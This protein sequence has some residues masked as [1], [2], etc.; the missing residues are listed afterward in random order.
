MSWQRV[1]GPGLFVLVGGWPG[2]GKSTLARALAAELRLPLLA[3]DEI[4]EAVARCVVPVEVARAR[5]DA[6]ADARHAAHFDRARTNDELWAPSPPLG[7]GSMIE[8]DTTAPTD[9]ALVASR[10][11]RAVGLTASS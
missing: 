11:L 10:V 2:S 8:V 1:D 9:A 3:K 6:R 5:Y 7:L 4:K